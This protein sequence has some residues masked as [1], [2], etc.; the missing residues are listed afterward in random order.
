MS[1]YPFVKS[2]EQIPAEC[3]CRWVWQSEK[4][5]QGWPCPEGWKL[6][7]SFDACP[8][9][10]WPPKPNDGSRNRH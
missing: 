4:D 7:N 5:R 8:A 6:T 1:V 10:P 3:L 9:H 2:L